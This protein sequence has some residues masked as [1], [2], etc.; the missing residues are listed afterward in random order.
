MSQTI[1]QWRSEIAKKV[2]INNRYLE[3]HVSDEVKI[4]QAIQGIPKRHLIQY[5][6]LY[7]GEEIKDELARQNNATLLSKYTQ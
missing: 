7:W 4:E 5:M 1:Q 6:A 2:S 3:L